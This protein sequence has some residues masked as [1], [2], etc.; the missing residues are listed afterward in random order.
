MLKYMARNKY[1]Y[2][3]P[4]QKAASQAY[5]FVKLAIIFIGLKL[6]GLNILDDLVLLL[7]SVFAYEFIGIFYH[8]KRRF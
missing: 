1:Y 8:P 4:S 7:I 3:T 2:Y 5:H 6:V